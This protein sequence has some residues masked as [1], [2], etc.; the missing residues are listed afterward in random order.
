VSLRIEER[1]PHTLI[2]YLNNAKL[3]PVNQLQGLTESIQ[4]YG[5]LIPILIDTN[6]V[7]VAGHARYEAATALGLPKVPCIVADHLSPQQVDEFRILD[8]MLAETGHDVQVLQSEIRRLNLDLKP[9]YL[10]LAPIDVTLDPIPTDEQM[11]KEEKT[12]VCPECNHRFNPK[13]K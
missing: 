6:N 11:I 3:H 7:I 5:F 12:V 1:E 2:P 13:G 9:F 4:Q 8:N 10:H